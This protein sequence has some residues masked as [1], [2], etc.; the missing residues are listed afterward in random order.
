MRGL[1][2]QIGSLSF[3]F[4]V[5]AIPTLAQKADLSGTW[6]GKYTDNIFTGY[7]SLVLTVNGESAAGQF[8]TDSDKEGTISGNVSGNSLT[9]ELNQ[10]TKS[11]TGSF[12][13]DLAFQ[14]NALNGEYTG[15]DCDGPKRSGHLA[16]S[17]S[18]RYLMPS[19]MRTDDGAFIPIDHIY[20]HGLPIWTLQTDRFFLGASATEVEGYIGLSLFI[21]NRTEQP[22]TVAPDDS[23]VLDMVTKRFL[24]RYSPEEIDK[25]IQRN[26]R[27][28]AF[29]VGFASGI[30]SVRQGQFSAY[31]QY[32]NQYS[33]TYKTSDDSATAAATERVW[34]NAASRAARIDSSAMLKHTILPGDSVM[35]SIF[36]SRPSKGNLMEPAHLDEKGELFSAQVQVGTEKFRFLFPIETFLKA[37]QNR[38]K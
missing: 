11:C 1:V 2:R 28:R 21:V 22:V 30:G 38:S 8:R 10:T 12:K 6:I 17:R 4:I 26:A 25:K 31:D 18:D 24:R 15:G 29:L 36:F 23:M 13:L 9:L 20:A 7:T 5:L 19:V 35:G 34:N 14:D 33:G 27:W 3:L 32:G 37:T 16:L